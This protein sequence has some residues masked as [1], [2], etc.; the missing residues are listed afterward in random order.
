MDS[1]SQMAQIYFYTLGKREKYKGTDGTKP[2][3]AKIYT[4]KNASNKYG[5]QN[6]I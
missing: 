2:S 4:N 5:L 3:Q 6:Y 1:K